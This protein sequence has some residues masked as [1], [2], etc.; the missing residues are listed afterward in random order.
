MS[1]NPHMFNAKPAPNGQVRI[2]F[3]DK[4]NRVIAEMKLANNAAGIVSAIILAAAQDSFV[5]AKRKGESIQPAAGQAQRMH[6]LPTK[7]ALTQ[8]QKTDFVTL[9][10]ECGE[11]SIGLELHR[12]VLQEI[13]SAMLALSA[14]GQ[15]Q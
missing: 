8:G 4:D 11:A 2:N 9:Y 15:A 6:I 7:V 14:G 3:T 1:S 10:F 5:E 12:T 13:G